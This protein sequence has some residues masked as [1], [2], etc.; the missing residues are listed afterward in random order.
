[1]QYY[2]RD[3]EAKC[4]VVEKLMQV[5]IQEVKIRYGIFGIGY[6]KINAF[7]VKVLIPISD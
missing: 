4:E 5:V 7:N 6:C 1:M 2:F 3:S